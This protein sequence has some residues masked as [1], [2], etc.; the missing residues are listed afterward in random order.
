[1]PNEVG[2]PGL[3]NSQLGY[4]LYQIIIVDNQMFKLVVLAYHYPCIHWPIW[5][6]LAVFTKTLIEYVH[7]QSSTNPGSPTPGAW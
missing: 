7:A 5:A 2:E 4:L 1:M 3:S 6:Y